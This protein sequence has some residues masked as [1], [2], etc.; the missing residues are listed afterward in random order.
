M[1][2]LLM[3]YNFYKCR[4]WCCDHLA[5]PIIVMS[6]MIIIFHANYTI[7]YLAHDFVMVLPCC[8]KNHN[9]GIWECNILICLQT[10]IFEDNAKYNSYFIFLQ[11]IVFHGNGK[12]N[13]PILLWTLIFCERMT[14]MSQYH[15]QMHIPFP[16]CLFI[17]HRFIN[18]LFYNKGNESK[19]SRFMFWFYML[20]NGKC[21]R[22]FK[23]ER[24]GPIAKWRKQC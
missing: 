1:L 15:L 11:I 10:T 18:G 16:I 13:T 22:Q 9:C 12:C 23:L 24:S 17:L 20:G 5:T 19:I 6:F 7:Y 4:W 8:L 14:T 2:L 3:I 21:A